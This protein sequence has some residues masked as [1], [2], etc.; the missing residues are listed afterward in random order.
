[1]NGIVL[2]GESAEKVLEREALKKGHGL[3]PTSYLELPT[4]SS[5]A[6]LPLKDSSICIDGIPFHHLDVLVGKQRDFR[7]N[8][9]ITFH[10]WKG[11]VPHSGI[12]KISEPFTSGYFV[13]S[14]TF[15]AIM[16]ARK[17]SLPS[18]AQ[19]VMYLCGWYCKHQKVP[20]EQRGPFTSTE[21]IALMLQSTRGTMGWKRLSRILPYCAEGVRSPPEASFFAVATFPRDIYGYQFPKPEVNAT[22]PVKP[23][24]EALAGTPSI[25]VDFYWSDAKL[26]V[27]YNGLDTHDGGVT[28]LDI[29]QQ[30]ILKEEGYEVIFLTKEQFSNARLLDLV[31]RHIAQRL[32]IDPNDGWPSMG[33]VQE[34]VDCLRFENRH[35]TSQ[36]YLEAQKRWIRR[37]N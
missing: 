6:G 27:E 9:S 17:L 23:E 36:E 31:M 25:E 29:T 26:V 30:L 14:A 11:P 37:N 28:P 5:Y 4:T 21:K 15:M 24:H 22:I 20:L 18:L 35:S 12:L 19:Y 34:L 7:R 3:E 1:M 32:G 2:C 13:T 16:A 33:N 10:Q 8:D